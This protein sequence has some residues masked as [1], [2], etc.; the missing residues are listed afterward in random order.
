MITIDISF[1]AIQSVKRNGCAIKA[2]IETRMNQPHIK[3]RNVEMRNELDLYVNVVNCKSIDGVETRHKNID[4]V[5]VRQVVFK[6][7]PKIFI[8]PCG[9]IHSSLFI[10]NPI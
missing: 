7:I 1:Q 5:V 3:S 9:I 6:K 4:I 2:N 10:R 8:F